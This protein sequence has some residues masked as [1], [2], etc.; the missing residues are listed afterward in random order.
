MGTDIHMVVEEWDG[1][2]W[3]PIA[4]PPGLDPWW[5]SR[6]VTYRWCSDRNYV[7]FAALADVRNG[8]GFAGREIFKP[9]Q[10]LT[11]G[12]GL[13]KDFKLDVEDPHDD[14]FCPPQAHGVWLGEHSYTWCTLAEVLAYDWDQPLTAIGV[15]SRDEYA[16]WKE[17]GR[18][19]SWRSW[20]SGPG[21]KIVP[22]EEFEQTTDTDESRHYTQ[23]Q[24]S[25]PLRESVS[26]FLRELDILK[27]HAEKHGRKLSEIRLVMGFDS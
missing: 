12:R 7:L 26:S 6:G 22:L 4:R 3:R 25:K 24:W 15:V 16:V 10:P 5:D 18:P 13:P 20:I 14:E 19:K 11:D 1:V 8:F 27:A 21:V 9:L 23:V 2:S 17:E